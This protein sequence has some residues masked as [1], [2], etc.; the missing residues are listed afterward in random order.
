MAANVVQKP[1]AISLLDFLQQIL[2]EMSHEIE[3][4]KREI[5]GIK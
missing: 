4:N 3:Q 2:P 1:E 5:E